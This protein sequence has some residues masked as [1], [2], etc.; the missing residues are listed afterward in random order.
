MSILEHQQFGMV[1]SG[2]CAGRVTCANM[3]IMIVITAAAAAN[4]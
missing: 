4:A 1:K 2:V 3:V